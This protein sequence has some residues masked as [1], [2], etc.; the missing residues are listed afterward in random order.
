ME[1]SSVGITHSLLLRMMFRDQQSLP[2][3]RIRSA[4]SSVNME[5]FHHVYSSRGAM[6]KN[7]A[8]LLYL[9]TILYMTRHPQT[10][11]YTK[12]TLQHQT[13]F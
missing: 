13:G 10:A 6:S 2:L 3:T 5:G 12:D 9:H 4:V 7:R 8:T 1:M 11:S